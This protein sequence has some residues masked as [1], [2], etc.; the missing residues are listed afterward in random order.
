MDADGVGRRRRTLAIVA[1]GLAAVVLGLL[2]Q[3]SGALSGVERETLTARFALRHAAPPD[4]VVVIGIDDATF[5]RLHHA[6]PLPRSWHARIVDRLRAAGARAVVYDVQ[7]TEATKPREDLALYDAVGRAGGAILATTELDARGRTDVLGGDANLARVHARAAAAELRT[8]G[9]RFA[10]FRHDVRGLPTVAVATAERVTG[11][12]VPLAPF[13]GGGAWIDFRGPAGTVPTLSFADV[14]RGRFDARAVRGRIIVVG[15]VAATLQDV[16]PTP[17]GGAELMSGPEIQANAI[18]TALHGFPLRAARAGTDLLLIALLGLLPALARLRLRVLPTAALALAA[19]AGTLAAAQLAFDHGWIVAV[20]VPLA[21]LV[22]GTLATVL[23]SHLVE[24]R[25]RRRLSRHAELLEAVVHERTAELRATQLEVLHRLGHAAESR[26]GET[27]EHIRRIGAL[28]ERLGLALGLPPADAE[29]LGHASALHD[30]GK[31][32]IPDRI[33]LKPGRLD[34]EEWAVMQTHTT[35]GA[36]ILAGSDAPLV[37]LAEEIARTHHERWDGTGYPVG[38]AGEAIPLAGRIVAVVD[39]FDALRSARP[40]KP[41]W[42]FADSLA[43]LER[44]RAS[45][46]DPAVLDA[47]LAIAGEAERATRADHGAWEATVV[48][49]AAPGAIAARAGTRA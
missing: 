11:R 22:A 31:V 26:D 6:W 18:W 16:H 33:L 29:L 27:G 9:G 25:E 39:V 47:F 1:G 49:A 3:L 12:P 35:L 36:D 40:Y 5:G 21:T 17:L 46:F 38:L 20:A 14:Y 37:R 30:V 15:A 34:P 19:A 13:D 10:R 48:P 24:S 7:F 23:A 4:D 8:E 42:T 28:A 43:E 41:A 32:G 44:G 45:H 2:T